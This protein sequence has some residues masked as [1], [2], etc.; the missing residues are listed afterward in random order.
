MDN[1][2]GA[3]CLLVR[4]RARSRLENTP[5]WTLSASSPARHRAMAGCSTP[6]SGFQE[7]RSAAKVRSACPYATTHL[8]QHCTTRPANALCKPAFGVQRILRSGFSPPVSPNVLIW[9]DGPGPGDRSTVAQAGGLRRKS[10]RERRCQSFTVLP[11]PRFLASRREHHGLWSRPKPVPRTPPPLYTCRC[12]RSWVMP[13]TSEAAAC[14]SLCARSESARATAISARHPVRSPTPFAPRVLPGR[15]GPPSCRSLP[16]RSQPP[17][18]TGAC[19]PCRRAGQ[20]GAGMGTLANGHHRWPP[21]LVTLRGYQR[22]WLRGDLI[23]GVTVAAY[24]VPQVMAY[25]GVAGL[26]PVG[27]PVGRPGPV[28]LLRGARLVAAGVAGPP[29]RAP[30]RIR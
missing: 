4:P 10:G 30:R 15:H 29:G 9:G 1:V 23:A 3:A 2:W 14:S 20:E 18:D 13:S 11:L 16:Q 12:A 28:G 17:A 19:L 25:A 8:L 5:V 22:A 24:L 6:P 21:G 7:S 26:P 27:R